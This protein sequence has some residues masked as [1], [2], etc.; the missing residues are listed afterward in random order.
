MKVTF[1]IDTESENYNPH[2][3]EMLQQAFSMMVALSGIQDKLRSWVKW[4]HE[5]KFQKF[6]KDE[7]GNYKKNSKGR[8]IKEWQSKTVWEVPVDEIQD[9][10]WDIITDAGVNMEKMGY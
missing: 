4:G 10:L 8:R 5:K 7:N 2:E 6:V 3:L 1:T 9:E